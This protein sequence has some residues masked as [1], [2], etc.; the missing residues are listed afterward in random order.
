MPR[1][2]VAIYTKYIAIPATA[3]DLFRNNVNRGMEEVWGKS[4]NVASYVI[5]LKLQSGR[6]GARRFVGEQNV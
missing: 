6:Y 4:K 5:H 1:H 2:G 3:L